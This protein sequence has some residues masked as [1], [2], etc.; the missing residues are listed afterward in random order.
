MTSVPYTTEDR[1]W[2]CRFN[3][4][5]KQY[6]DTIIQ[7]IKDEDG[8]GKFKYILIGGVEVGTRPHQNDFGCEH[9][10]VA[11]LFHNRAS[12]SSIIK[13]WN[14]I[15]GHGYYLV[16]RN[17]DLPYSGWRA[18]H[19]KEFSKTDATTTLLYE[20]GTLPPDIKA[21]SKVE[22]GPEEKKRKLDEILI[23]M[24]RM[25]EE[26]DD[27]TAWTK[28]PRNYLTYGEKIKAMVHQK[29][30]FF[31]THR[32]PNIWVYGYAGTGKTS[33]MSFIYPNYYKKNLSNRFFD[34]YDSNIHT[35]I[36][37]EDLDHEAV[38]RLGI[39]FIKTICDEAGFPIDQKYKTPQLVQT[40]CLITS[41]FSI[42]EIMNGMDN[43]TGLEQNKPALLRRFYHVRI[44]SLLHLLGLK[45]LPKWDRTKLHKEGNCDMS[46]LY[47]T[48]DY[49]TDTPL[50]TPVQTPEHYQK[51]IRDHFYQ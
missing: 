14:I 4:P 48:W 50:C 47:I 10:H 15:E 5:N 8:K 45:L 27:T 24:R 34:L 41:N 17:R 36:M 22:A 39:N 13:N 16:P 20:S 35:H 1:Q 21:R 19:I 3:V 9:I 29:R 12:K 40:T 31:K 44:D 42:I 33:L 38:D 18:H 49:V 32:D 51:V 26:G 23:D 25:I 11:A 6:L 43:Q 46:K 30:E 37:L 28:Y 7:S 2:D